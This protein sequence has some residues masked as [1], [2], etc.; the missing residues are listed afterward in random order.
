MKILEVIPQL[1]SGGGERFTVD[2]CNE[3]SKNNEVTLLTYY[4]SPSSNF[5][6]PDLSSA[7]RHISLGKNIGFSLRMFTQVASVIASENPDVVHM[8]LRAI[9][10]L[11]PSFLFRRRGVRYYMTIHSD[12]EKEAGGKLGGVLRMICFKCKMVSPITISDASCESFRRYYGMSAPMIFNGRSIP[13]D[14]T[15]SKSVHAEIDSYK[16]TPSTR[17]IAN[18]ARFSKEKRQPLLAKVTSRLFAEGYDFTVLY[19]GGVRDESILDE[20]RK[21]ISPNQHIVG[22]KANV[23][24]YLALSDAFCLCS[25]YEGLP[26]S[27]IEALGVGTVPVCTPA[28]GIVDL[29]KDGENGIL[30]SDFSEDALYFALKRFLETTIDNLASMKSFAKSAYQPY[31]MSV[32]AEKYSQL[33]SSTIR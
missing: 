28:G 29:I 10:Y 18:I 17:V 23:L 3:L 6:L 19:I 20:T 33:F 14:F 1:S 11:L 2:L 8:H 21:L 4:N 12:A 26:I 25:S 16:I 5:Y 24:D 31:S 22:E 13:K 27:L 9:N 30:A 15:A 32:C 7:V